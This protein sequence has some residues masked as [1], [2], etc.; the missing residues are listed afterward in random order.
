MWDVLPGCLV[1]RSLITARR[2][3]EV[4][5][6]ALVDEVLMPGLTRTRTKS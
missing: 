6:R 4:T 3:T 2:P 5:L 1:F